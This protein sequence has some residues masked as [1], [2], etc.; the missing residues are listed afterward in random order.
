MFFRRKQWRRLESLLLMMI[1]EMYNMQANID[2]LRQAVEQQNTV[3]SS[4]KTML[5]TMAQELRAAAD[6]PEEIRR[7]AEQVEANN[8][9]LADAAVANTGAESEEEG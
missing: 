4:V 6:D 2:R 9:A 1:E 8:Q 5:S 3:V 7:L